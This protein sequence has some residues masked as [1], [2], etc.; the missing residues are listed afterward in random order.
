MPLVPIG[1]NCTLN[2]N[3]AT[4]GSPTWSPVTIV[5]DLTLDIEQGVT[6]ANSRGNQ[7]WEVS[8]LTRKKASV[9]FDILDK[10]TDTNFEAIR[11]AFLNKTALDMAVLDEAVATVGAQGLRAD[12]AITKFSRNEPQEG[13]VTYSVSMIPALTDNLP[14][15]METSA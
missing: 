12:W 4:Y 1:L 2:R 5:R 6:E 13:V 8:L 15:W 9:S 7:A 3:T 14:V 11:D 10:P